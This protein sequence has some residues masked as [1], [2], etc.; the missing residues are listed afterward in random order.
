MKNLKSINLRLLVVLIVI[1][2]MNNNTIAQNYGQI[3]EN[4]TLLQ[5]GFKA[6]S[7]LND[8]RVNTKKSFI[9]I[10][11]DSLIGSLEI[12]E[13]EIGLDFAEKEMNMIVEKNSIKTS[14]LDVD[15]VWTL[16]TILAGRRCYVTVYSEISFAVLKNQFSK[17]M[18]FLNFPV[19]INTSRVFNGILI[20]KSEEAEWK[21]ELKAK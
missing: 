11:R 5:N 14:G 6:S 13:K 1:V 9:A 16:D 21:F 19:N 8:N 18:I 10:F 12:N 3:D 20:Y 15:T 7:L 2:F 4:T 17:N